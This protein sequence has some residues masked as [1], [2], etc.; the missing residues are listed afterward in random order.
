MN[1]SSF[2]DFL[3]ENFIFIHL[4]R[5]KVPLIIDFTQFGKNIINDYLQ[6]E[7]QQD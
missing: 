3:K 5:D 4:F 2:S 7:K 6:F 1:S